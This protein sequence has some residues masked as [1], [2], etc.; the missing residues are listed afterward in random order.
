ME[1]VNK[2]FGNFNT[3]NKNKKI[4]KQINNQE[5]KN[6][7]DEDSD[8]EAES[9]LSELKNKKNKTANKINTNN[10]NNNKLT[11]KTNKKSNYSNNKIGIYNIGDDEKSEENSINSK[12]LFDHPE[13]GLPEFLREAY[14]RDKSGRQMDHP[15]YDPTTLLVP[16]EYIQKCTPAMHQYWK[17]KSENFD[18]VLFFKLGKFYELFYD[19]AIVGNKVLDLNWMGNDPKRLHV[20]FPEKVLEERAYVLIQNGFKVAVIEQVETVQELE[21]RLKKTK[22]A[23]K[24][25]KC[26]KRDLCNV[27]TKGTFM[28][29]SA[30][31]E[32]KNNYKNKFCIT[33]LCTKLYKHDL[34]KKNN[35]NNNNNKSE[36][37]NE[38]KNNEEN[39]FDNPF[40]GYEWHFIIFDVTTVNFLFGSIS[41]DDEN[42]TKIKTLLYNINP[43]EVIIQKNNLEDYIIN[44]MHSLSSRPQITKMKNDFTLLN[45]FKLTIKHFG[46]NRAEW[47]KTLLHHINEENEKMLTTLYYTVIYLE[48][49]LLAEQLLKIANFANYQANMIIS[50]NLILDFQTVS[51]L[52]ILETKLDAK[53]SEAGSLMEYM[54]QAVSPFG[55]RKMKQWILNPLSDKSEIETRLDIVDDLI[56]NFDCVNAFRINAAKF[57]DLE[58]LVAKIYKFSIQSN[59]KAIYFE[60]FAKTRIQDFFKTISAFKKSIEVFK[61]FKA[62]LNNFKSNK[63]KKKISL[64]TEMVN[65][66]DRNTQEEK[67][68]NGEVSNIVDVLEDLENYY[69]E[70][71]NENGDTILIPK[72]GV[73]ESY[74]EYVLKIDEIK[75]KFEKIL[76]E[77]KIK[78]KCPVINFTHTKNYKYELE[79]PEDYVKAKNLGSHYKLTTS[80]KGFMRYHTTQIEEL[81]E[82]FEMYQDLKKKENN[83]FNIYLFQKFYSKNQEISSYIESLA[84]LDCHCALA[85]IS[86]QVLIIFFKFFFINK[87]GGEMTRPRFIHL[88]ENN[89]VPYLN[90]KNSKHPCIS[91]KIKYFVPN[92]IVIGE[93]NKTALVI[94]GPNMGGKSTILRQACVLVIMAQVGCYV[95]ADECILTPKD[96]IFTRIGA[97]DK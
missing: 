83:K 84:E 26:I 33:L 97:K 17:F 88:K 61:I 9:E 54:N 63:L 19:D 41:H 52:E 74:D 43:Q 23:S 71:K 64:V 24:V 81:I 14:I 66:C 55:M 62:N 32:N 4:N 80:K 46:E 18:K 69:Q 12:N 75:G 87:K 49:L 42:Y 59:N 72:D 65:F 86:N 20:G 56:A 51:N 76:K 11:N 37:T 67:F 93:N 47:N 38:E 7:D 58:R 6:I 16:Q 45:L 53:N 96:R 1:Y 3:A 29:E 50:K 21:E 36:K 15:D 78:L 40:V 68:E 57:A 39:I 60:D 34:D 95:S 8:F 13:E 70:S 44:F 10:N 92:D 22:G 89:G 28:H 35:N 48:N 27:F 25:D 30:K 5:S 73:Q 85:Y 79:I 91:Q 31:F 2:L 94:T 90:V 82:E 77:E